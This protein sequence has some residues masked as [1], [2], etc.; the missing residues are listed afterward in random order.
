MKTQIVNAQRATM[1]TFIDKFVTQTHL[2]KDKIPVI[3][4][5]YKLF[6]N[7]KLPYKRALKKEISY[8]IYAGPFAIVCW[9]VPKTKTNEDKDDKLIMTRITVLTGNKNP[10][11]Q[12]TYIVRHSYFGWMTQRHMKDYYVRTN[13]QMVEF[14]EQLKSQIEGWRTHYGFTPSQF[15]EVA[16]EQFTVEM[17][18]GE[19][20]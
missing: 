14:V 13:Q 3:E 7:E 16:K 10:S 19:L 8:G 18:V 6:E 12:I 15:V 5:I 4:K 20:G 2:R 17:L 9:K 11:I 1:E